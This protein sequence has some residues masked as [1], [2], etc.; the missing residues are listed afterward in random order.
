MSYMNESA[1]PGPDTAG[2]EAEDSG[3]IQATPE[4]EAADTSGVQNASEELRPAEEGASV[5]GQ[6]QTAAVVPEAD[7]TEPSGTKPARKRGGKKKQEEP[8]E[9]DAVL[10]ESGGETSPEGTGEAED[11]AEEAMDREAPEQPDGFPEESGIPGPQAD[12]AAAEQDAG[13][14]PD[15][16][17]AGGPKRAARQAPRPRREKSSRAKAEVKG[18]AQTDRLKDKPLEGRPTLSDL[19]LNK[20]DRE[21][22]DREREEWNE[23]YASLRSRTILT[24]TVVGIDTHSFKVRDRDTKRIEYR[25]ILCA[26][27]I[28]YRVKVLIPET[29]IWQPG[30][31]R[32]SHVLRGMAGAEIDYVILDV[33]RE[34]G[35]AIA[36]R[37]LGLAARQHYF[38]AEKNGHKIGEYLTC[39]VVSVGP[40]L[41]M[42]ECGGRDMTLKQADLTYT[43]TPD[44]RERYRPG[45]KLRCVLTEYDPYRQLMNISVKAATINP[46]QGAIKRH[47]VNSRRQATISGKYGGGVFCTLPDDS[48]CLCRYSA[49]QRDREFHVGDSVIIV[50]TKHN[51]ERSMIYGRIL[52][53]W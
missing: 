53:K 25:E 45:Q 29:E 22:T 41:C 51:F 21:L 4:N 48:V 34:G 43:A 13:A 19:D 24:G 38:N 16:T 47:P 15:G 20:L 35:V 8:A 31:E 1:W 33:D 12:G 26:V 46:F 27:V 7:T 6:E 39:R 36:S 37:K 2:N 49:Q 50:I 40:R 17:A 9:G 23:I 10:G 28:A 11:A 14:E 5:A 18:T 44:L 32:P 30:S 52:S 42:V 3:V